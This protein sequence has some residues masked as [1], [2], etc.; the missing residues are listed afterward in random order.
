MN[1]MDATPVTL[2]SAVSSSVSRLEFESLS[3]SLASGRDGVASAVESLTLIRTSA[4]TC[5]GL[6]FLRMN[7]RSG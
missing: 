6:V 7:R 5:K 2:R 3:V 1:V 4:Q